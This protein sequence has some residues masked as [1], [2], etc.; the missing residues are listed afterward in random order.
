M[1]D[2][3]AR[4]A[5]LHRVLRDNG[6]KRTCDA[7]RSWRNRGVSIGV[8]ERKLYNIPGSNF[9]VMADVDRDG[10]LEQIMVRRRHR[11]RGRDDGGIHMLFRR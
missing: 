10:D 3:R 7:A 6:C 1:S 5:L 8:H 11:F 2:R 4:W 9:I